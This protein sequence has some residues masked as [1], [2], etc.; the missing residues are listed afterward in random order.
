ML[1]DNDNVGN[2]S[3][4]R[5][6]PEDNGLYAFEAVGPCRSVPLALQR[7]RLSIPCVY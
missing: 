5:L 6:E 1:A 7:N 4:Y 2:R 3:P